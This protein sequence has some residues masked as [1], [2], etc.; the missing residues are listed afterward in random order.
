MSTPLPAPGTDAMQRSIA[1][2]LLFWFLVIALIPCA[3]L[4]LI[5]ARIATQA[6]ENSV[7]NTLV[8]T[9]AAK[10]NELEAYASERVRD[11]TALAH[12]AVLGVGAAVRAASDGASVVHARLGELALLDAAP[13]TLHALL[14]AR[15]RGGAAIGEVFVGRDVC[16]Q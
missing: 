1:G 9:A 7:R 3:I 8:Q 6:L 5:T 4:T 16:G 2:R 13:G 12:V 15:A 10:A 14:L 11:G